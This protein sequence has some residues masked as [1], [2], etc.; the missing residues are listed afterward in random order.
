MWLRPT[1]PLLV[2]SPYAKSN[3]ID[4]TLTDQTSIVSFIEYNWGLGNLGPTS[5]DHLSGSLLNMFD[6]SHPQQNDGVL[7]MN[8]STGEIVQQDNHSPFPFF[9]SSPS[10]SSPTGSTGNPS[11]GTT[12]TC[13]DTD[14]NPDVCATSNDFGKSSISPGDTV[15]FSA[16]ADITPK[17]SASP[18]TVHYTGQWINLQLQGGNGLP[19]QI[20]APNSE[21]IF[22]SSA[23]TATTTFTGGQW[24]TTVPVGFQGNLFIGGVAYKVPTGVSLAGAKVDWTGIFSGTTNSF[25]LQ[26]QWGA[27]IYSGLGTGTTGSSAYYTAL[28]VKPIDANSGSAYANNN[29]AGTPEN[30][31]A[32][33]LSSATTGSHP[34]PSAVQYTGAYNRPGD[35][36]YQAYLL[37]Q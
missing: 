31:V 18:L 29:P 16:S 3:Y 6:F 36:Y 13:T 23:T 1:N 19:L 9:D 34:G 25:T 5:Y 4:N 37:N 11:L 17:E 8:P 10:I 26:W 14:T 21:V 24:V 28:G 2:I 35:A 22:S 15:W 32:D 27:A 12:G 7:L 30:F 20:P 33:F